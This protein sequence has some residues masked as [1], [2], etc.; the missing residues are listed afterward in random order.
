MEFETLIAAAVGGTSLFGGSGSALRTVGGVLVLG[1][2]NNSLILMA[3]PYEAQL[4][5]KGSVFLLIV[6]LDGLA[7]QSS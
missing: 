3:V 5:A 2:L 7:R 1:V 6:W 4:A